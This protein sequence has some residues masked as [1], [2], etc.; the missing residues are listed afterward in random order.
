MLSQFNC[1]MQQ[2][3][4]VRMFMTDL[5]GCRW[6]LAWGPPLH[7]AVCL[8]AVRPDR[9]ISGKEATPVR[10]G[11]EAVHERFILYRQMRHFCFIKC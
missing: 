4:S 11:D 3:F 8:E 6:A 7:A 1:S 5:A 2:D 9:D 10:D